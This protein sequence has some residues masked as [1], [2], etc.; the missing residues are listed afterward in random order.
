MLPR[1]LAIPLHRAAQ[2]A[3][4]VLVQG[5]RSSGKTVLLRRE[6]PAHTYLPLDDPALRERARQD[7]ATF[8]ARLRGPAFIDDLHR[9]PELI[10]HLQAEPTG[11]LVLASSVRI[12]WEVP[13]FELHPPTQAERERRPPLS[14]AMLGHFVPAAVESG[15]AFPRWPAGRSFLDLDLPRLVQ[16]RDRDR[17]ERFFRLAGTRSGQILD[18]QA[19]AR[20]SGVSHRTAVRWLEVLDACFQ[21]VL[22]PPAPF[23]LGRRVVRSPKIHFLA[24]GEFESRVVSELYRNAHHAGVAPDLCYWRDSNGLEVSLLIRSDVAPPVPV[25]ISAE[26]HPAVDV[27]LRRWMQL[28]GIARGALITEARGPARRQGVLRYSA[29]QL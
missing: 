18:Q 28:A 19:L 25:A 7:P 2:R 11:R 10:A 3:G 29:D 22:L 21:T 6:F 17:F 5:P 24:S 16:V 26:A 23:T 20:E 1:A 4:P 9:A 8:L 27:R 14:L 13:T 15:P 12:R